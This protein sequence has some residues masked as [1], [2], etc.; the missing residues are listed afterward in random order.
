MGIVTP[1]VGYW[2]CIS[3]LA[4]WMS[5][6]E[7][8]RR[9]ITQADLPIQEVIA[10]AV[11]CVREVKTFARETGQLVDHV[12]LGVLTKLRSAAVVLNGAIRA[13]TRGLSV[14]AHSKE[15]RNL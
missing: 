7:T 6:H 2:F 1:A 3:V 14:A 5:L 10:Q 11:Y 9:Q 8:R 13:R 15:Y 4:V 12:F